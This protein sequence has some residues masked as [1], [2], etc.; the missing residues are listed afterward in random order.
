[1]GAASQAAKKASISFIQAEIQKAVASYVSS[2]ISSAGVLGWLV[3]PLAM[4]GGAAFGSLMG[5]AIQR[6]EFA[7]KGFDGVVN[8]PTMFMTGENNKAE[9]VSITPLESPNISGAQG[10]GNINI[11]I[12]A[13]TAD[14]AV[15][16]TIIPALERAKALNLA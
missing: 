13:M 4:A 8:Q 3:A 9:R 6:I 15:I 7:E 16:D 5:S 14:E 10:G 11:N 12:S 1:M 2:Q